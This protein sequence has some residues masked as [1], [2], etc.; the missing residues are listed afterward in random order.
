MQVKTAKDT[1]AAD[2]PKEAQK[3]KPAQNP[4]ERRC[5]D[6]HNGLLACARLSDSLRE[7]HTWFHPGSSN[8]SP[9]STARRFS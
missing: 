6:F 2:A 3:A 4:P 9:T 5:G 8:N 1:K 7:V